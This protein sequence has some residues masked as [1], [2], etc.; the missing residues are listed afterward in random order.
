MNLDWMVVWEHRERFLEGAAMTI[1]LTIATMAL[2]I[3]GGLALA[4]LRMSRWAA[5]R[6]PAD[7]QSDA[8]DS[9]LEYSAGS[10]GPSA[11]RDRFDRFCAAHAHWL[12]DYALFMAVKGA[13][14]QRPWTTWSADIARRE[15]AAVAA[16]TKRCAR[17]IRTQYKREGTTPKWDLV[18]TGVINPL[19][20]VQDRVAEEL[21]RY[22]PRDAV[23]PVDRDPVPQK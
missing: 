15:T 7:S 17:E 13:H 10:S 5:V 22:G 8:T 4:F 11:T 14:D 3:P 18:E 1:F 19:R 23:V 20:I 6:A 2:A 21:A 9:S 12:N 16:W